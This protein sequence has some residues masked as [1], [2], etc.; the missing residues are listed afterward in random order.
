MVQLCEL[1]RKF[2]NVPCNFKMDAVCY[3]NIVNVWKNKIADNVT[4]TMANM[5]LTNVQ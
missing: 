1:T 5:R 2:L 4:R 3:L